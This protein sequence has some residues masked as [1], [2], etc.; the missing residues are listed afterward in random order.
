[1]DTFLLV[2]VRIKFL[3]FSYLLLRLCMLILRKRGRQVLLNLLMM[4][5][6]S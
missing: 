1:M 4:D 3:S 6:I 5:G 2:R